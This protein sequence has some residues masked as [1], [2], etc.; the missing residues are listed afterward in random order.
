[1]PTTTNTTPRILVPLLAQEIVANNG[2]THKILLTADHLTETAAN[3]SQV[4]DVCTMT[5]G[6]ILAKFEARLVT[7]FKDSGDAAF[8]STAV[9]FGDGGSA[10]RYISAAQM[11]EN[12]TE[13]ADPVYGNTA[14]QYTADGTL[15]L[16]VASMADKALNDINTGELLILVQIV[17]TRKF[18]EL[19]AGVAV[20]K[21]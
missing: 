11:N 17:E 8:N 7:P 15:R 16:T 20:L 19:I 14:Y 21:A 2:Y 1:M 3:T 5:D 13:I 18:T 12:G 4:I 10:T 9:S 6:D